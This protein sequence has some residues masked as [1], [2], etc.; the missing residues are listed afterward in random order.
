MSSTISTN[1]TNSSISEQIICHQWEGVKYRRADGNFSQWTDSLKDALILNSL[2]V[3]VFDTT[4]LRPDFKAEPHAYSNW[5][6][7]DHLAIT[8]IKSALDDTEHRVLVIDKGAS[9]CFSDLKTCVQREGLIEQVA[10]FQEALSTYCSLSK[11][12]P[13]TAGHIVDIVKRAFDI[14][15]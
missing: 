3:Y 2:Y 15:Q 7:N 6:P 10:L 5:G 4:I 9:S 12:L 1:T 14:G 11:P 13:T 8:F